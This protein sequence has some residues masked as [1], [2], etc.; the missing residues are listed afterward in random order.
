VFLASLDNSLISIRNLG[1]AIHE[2]RTQV[3]TIT[4]HN[5]DAS[6]IDPALVDRPLSYHPTFLRSK[7]PESLIGGIRL[8]IFG[9]A[10]AIT[11]KVIDFQNGFIRPIS[12]NE[13]EHFF[14]SGELGIES[15]ATIGKVFTDFTI[16]R[17]LPHLTRAEI[18]RYSNL[19][20]ED[21]KKAMAEDIV[22][23]F[24][25]VA[26]EPVNDR[27]EQATAAGFLPPDAPP[28]PAA[29]AQGFIA[30]NPSRFNQ[31]EDAFAKMTEKPAA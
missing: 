19:R 20:W 24:L 21:D 12:H 11:D 31:F 17:A 29:V 27:Y 22:E 8:T 4:D 7:I 3:V 6:I 2:S 25:P 28:S 5:I 23:R 9:C 30:V 1:R 15:N 16:R 13:R 18:D 26:F 10:H 14:R